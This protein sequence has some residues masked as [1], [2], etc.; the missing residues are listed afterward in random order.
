[1]IKCG[2]ILILGAGTLSLHILNAIKPI[3]QNVEIL[4][5]RSVSNV[6]LKTY[7]NYVFDL[8]DLAHDKFSDYNLLQ[9][10]INFRRFQILSGISFDKYIYLSSANLYTPSTMPV[11]EGS[12]IV[13]NCYVS[14]YLLN[15]K[16][17]EQELFKVLP[18]SLV[19]LRS[20]ALWSLTHSLSKTGF[21]G[22]LFRAKESGKILPPH[23]TDHLVFT[24]MSYLEAARMI[25]NFIE[26]NFYDQSL[27]NLTSS[28]WSTR[29]FVKNYSVTSRSQQDIN[30][31]GLRI[32]SNFYS[33]NML[34]SDFEATL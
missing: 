9:D 15:K 14:P 17:N 4:P 30:N 23:P 24:Y 21:F 22:D 34:N 31:T 27:I 18:H 8:L 32:V 16:A 26:N 5:S 10:S 33:M 12:N 29:E 2:N 11:T 28:I 6:P 7:Y 3:A 13:E 20:V 19:I 1:M 25:Y